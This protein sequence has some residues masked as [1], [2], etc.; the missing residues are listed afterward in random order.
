MPPY[1]PR[2]P[3]LRLSSYVLAV[4]TSA[5]HARP[6]LLFDLRRLPRLLRRGQG[7]AHHFMRA[8]F[9]SQVSY[10]SVSRGLLRRSS[11]IPLGA[12]NCLLVNVVPFA[13]SPLCPRK[14]VGFTP[15]RPVGLRHRRLRTPLSQPRL[16]L[17]HNG[18]SDGS[19]GSS[20]KARRLRISKTPLEK[21]IHGY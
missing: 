16:H 21:L 7:P 11:V 2:P 13:A 6:P 9:L 20:W 1:Y 12:Y 14:S 3:A 5:R 18:C 8:F 19:P 15:A 4:P 17:V 10:L